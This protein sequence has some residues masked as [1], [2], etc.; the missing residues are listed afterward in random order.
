[1]K[2]K[3]FNHVLQNVPFK[4]VSS[5]EYNHV[6]IECEGYLVIFALD[7]DIEVKYY[8]PSTY[9]NPE[10]YELKYTKNTSNIKVYLKDDDTELVLNNVQHNKLAQAIEE[11]LNVVY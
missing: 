4:E 6:E 9:T 8:S 10:E 11:N 5:G 2:T 3:E 7:C 1:M